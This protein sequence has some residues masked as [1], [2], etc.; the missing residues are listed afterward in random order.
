MKS[1]LFELYDQNVS[2]FA[3]FVV[4]Y[5]GQD[6]LALLNHLREEGTEDRLYEE[7]RHIYVN[8]PD[9]EFNIMKNP[10]G[11]AEFIEVMEY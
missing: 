2:A 6:T 3:W 4:D 7:L 1:D 11:W 8:L 5:F 9:S 10:E